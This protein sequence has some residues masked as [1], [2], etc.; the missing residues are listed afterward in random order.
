MTDY[1]D[2]PLKQL[3]LGCQMGVV[4][5]QYPI[6][7]VW[8]T[9]YHIW[10][11]FLLN[12]SPILVALHP[13]GNIWYKTIFNIKFQSH[14]KTYSYKRKVI[15]K[16]IARNSIVCQLFTQHIIIIDFRPVFLLFI[17]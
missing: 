4:S 3:I 1:R 8:G 7:K 13:H 14:L 17:I 5:N 11:T 15:V 6:L 12:T 10:E 16:V 2:A 9:F